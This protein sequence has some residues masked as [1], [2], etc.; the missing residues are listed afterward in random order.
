MKTDIYFYKIKSRVRV[1]NPALYYII[2]FVIL[3]FFG[4]IKIVYTS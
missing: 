3:L 2:V 1:I 4:F